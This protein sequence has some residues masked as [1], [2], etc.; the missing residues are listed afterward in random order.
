MANCRIIGNIATN[1]N[2]GAIYM[3]FASKVFNC[4]IRGNKVN[5][6][7]NSGGGVNMANP[8]SYGSLILRN[9]LVVGN[10]SSNTGG[11]IRFAQTN[12]LVEN[13]T[14]VSNIAGTNSGGI[15]GVAGYLA[16]CIVY[17]NT[18]ET[19]TFSNY[20]GTAHSFSNCCIAPSAAGTGNTTADPR[21]VGKDADNWQLTSQSPCV[22]FGANRNWMTNAVDLNGGTRIDGGTVDMGCYEYQYGAPKWY[23]WA[24]PFPRYRDNGDGTIT[25]TATSLMWLQNVPTNA[26]NWVSASNYC[27][28]LVSC[29]YSDWRLPSVYKTDGDGGL[30]G[31]A[32]LDTLGRAGGDPAGAWEGLAGANFTGVL[33]VYYWSRITHE[34]LDD[35]RWLVHSSDGSYTS[36]GTGASWRVWPVRGP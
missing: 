35:R 19:T 22:N 28:D 29:G 30:L 23:L 17:Y 10:V 13:C 27:A 14:I 33:S 4:E 21:F 5:N 24:K 2:G 32:E 6:P 18:S 1:G 25:D 34:D 8:T 11:G 31:T 12:A 16:N 20:D 7:V 15:G 3:R 26:M 36:E 9:C